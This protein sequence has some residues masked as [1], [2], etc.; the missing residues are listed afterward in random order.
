MTNKKLPVWWRSEQP[1][2]IGDCIEVMKD[3]PD[4]SIDLVVTSPPYNL[5]ID[6]NEYDDNIDWDEYINETHNN[7]TFKEFL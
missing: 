3:I 2:I 5:N 4:K 1:W 7:K 6:Y